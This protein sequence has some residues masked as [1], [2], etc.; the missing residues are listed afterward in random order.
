MSL[1]RERMRTY[2]VDVGKIGNHWPWKERARV[3]PYINYDFPYQWT[4]R[5]LTSLCW[6]C[7]Y[8]NLTVYKIPSRINDF[9]F[10]QYDLQMM[11]GVSLRMQNFLQKSMIFCFLS[12]FLWVFTLNEK[13]QKLH[14]K[15]KMFWFLSN[16]FL[17]SS[18]PGCGT[19]ESLIRISRSRS[20]AESFTWRLFNLI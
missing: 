14:K 18:A 5:K 19:P 12:S 1:I 10:L 8:C 16:F 20:S 4:I 13:L 2:P 9:V 17:V 3:N 6:Q 15:S 11:P 7:I